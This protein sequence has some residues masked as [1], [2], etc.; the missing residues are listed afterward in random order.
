MIVL[1]TQAVSPSWAQSSAGRTESP[2]AFFQSL[3][4][5]PLMP[6]L[7]EMLDESVIFDKPEGRIIESMAAGQGLAGQDIEQFYQQALPQF[8]WN[9][10]GADTYIRQGETLTLHV[11]NQGD[12][13][14]VRFMVAP[15]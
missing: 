1:L 15:R 13:K 4:D 14:I 11:E 7:Y 2:Q 12:Y 6:G 5:V 8:G 10:V 3:N 9:R